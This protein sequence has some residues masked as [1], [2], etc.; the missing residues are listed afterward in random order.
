M[1]ALTLGMFSFSPLFS[2][3][4][5]PQNWVRDAHQRHQNRGTVFMATKITA[6][7]TLP[8][9]GIAIV[10]LLALEDTRAPTNTTPAKC[11][12]CVK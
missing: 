9:K 5:F 11:L 6:V 8:F 2:S 1:R 12:F 7:P 4:F 10:A 3:F